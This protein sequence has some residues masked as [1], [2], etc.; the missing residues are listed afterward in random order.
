MNDRIQVPVANNTI[1]I[2]VV[3][4]GTDICNYNLKN[5]IALSLRENLLKHTASTKVI[6]IYLFSESFF[7]LVEPFLEFTLSGVSK[8]A[9]DI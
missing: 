9:K 1:G 4:T 7:A 2:F 5:Y 3:N 6:N 8:H